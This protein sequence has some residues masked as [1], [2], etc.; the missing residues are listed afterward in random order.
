MASLEK[1]LSRQDASRQDACI[2]EALSRQEASLHKDSCAE[3]NVQI[4]ALSRQVAT[5]QEALLH[6]DSCAQANAEV[7]TLSRQVATL[8]A[9][10]AAAMALPPLP[11]APAGLSALRGGLP[12]PAHDVSELA[13][14]SGL[15]MLAGPTKDH[16]LVA[17]LARPAPASALPPPSGPPLCFQACPSCGQGAIDCF[18]C[19]RPS[20]PREQLT[21]RF[22][23]FLHL[24]RFTG[25]LVDFFPCSLVD[26]FPHW[27]TDSL[28]P[29][30]TYSISDSDSP[31]Y[32]PFQP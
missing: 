7:E 22:T 31:I 14:R 13:G 11:T 10:A 20:A 2:K 28:A 9:A 12:P 6:R 26:R 23:A 19:P 3:A 4:E 25:S 21:T 8:Q 15:T 5:L 1:A 17:C 27:L 29:P 24:L 32:L 18:F 30:A 16:S